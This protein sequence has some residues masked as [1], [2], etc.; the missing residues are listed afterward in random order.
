[1]SAQDVKALERARA[2]VAKGW[3]QGWYAKGKSGKDVSILSKYAVQW[4][5]IGAFKTHMPAG[6]E[7]ALKQAIDTYHVIAWN[8]AKQRT[9]E[10]VLAAFD[11]AI[12]LAK[13]DL[14]AAN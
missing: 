1:M 13:A 10:E 8:D 4:C 9:Q 14:A 12:E 2:R 5:A 7:S 11:R 6:A 3:C